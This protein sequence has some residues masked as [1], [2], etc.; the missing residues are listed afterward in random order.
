MEALRQELTL[1]KNKEL[2]KLK[3]VN[4]S[5][6]ASLIRPQEALSQKHS[7]TLESKSAKVSQSN[8]ACH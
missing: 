6:I 8:S 5:V 2:E 1:Q 7:R 4:H 3:V